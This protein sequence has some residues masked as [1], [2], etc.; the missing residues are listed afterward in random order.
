M[1]TVPIDGRRRPWIPISSSFALDKTGARLKEE[2]GRDGLLV[3]TCLIAAA[4]R[5]AIQGSFEYAS[6]ADAWRQLGLY[7]HEPDFTFEDFLAVTDKLKLTIS[8]RAT[9]SRSSS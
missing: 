9:R 7:G 2:L 3:W 1:S 6:E 8:S 4:K 5:A